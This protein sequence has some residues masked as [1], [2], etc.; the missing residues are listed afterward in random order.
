MKLHIIFILIDFFVLMAYP[1]VFLIGK[2]DRML[3]IKR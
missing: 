1:I 2:L 3:K